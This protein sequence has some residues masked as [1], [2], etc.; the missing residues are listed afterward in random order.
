M[1][2]NKNIFISHAGKDESK[3]D[4]FKKMMESKKGYR[5]KDSSIRESE[6]NQANNP[7][8]IKQEYLRPSI[9]WA[10]TMIVLISKETHKS[11]WV[12]WEIEYALKTGA[13][14]VGVFLPG[15]TNAELPDALKDYGNACVSWNP[16]KIDEAIQGN[17]IWEDANGN[18]SPYGSHGRSTC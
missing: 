17:P 9:K 5:F 6:P 15:E 4:S 10:G 2:K 16:D 1:S 18:T 3:I 12:N 14:I 11:D 7:E 13:C 8:Y